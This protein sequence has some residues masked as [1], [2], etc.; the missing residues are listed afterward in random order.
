MRIVRRLYWAWILTASVLAV[1]P[2]NA[3]EINALGSRISPREF[4]D[5][6]AAAREAGINRLDP[7][8]RVFRLL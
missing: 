7:P 4:E 6:L 5:A 3:A 1:G 8:R 2:L